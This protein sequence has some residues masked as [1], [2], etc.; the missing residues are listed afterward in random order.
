MDLFQRNTLK[1]W[2]EYGGVSKKRL[3]AYKNSNISKTQ[4]DSTKVTKT[5]Y[6]VFS[7]NKSPISTIS[8]EI[9]NSII[10]RV[11]N[12]KYLEVIIN[13]QL[14]WS[15]HIESVEQQESRAAARKPRDAASV[16]F[17]SLIHI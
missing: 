3:S 17:L 6:S 16:L 10:N 7:P 8:L 12:C 4:Q 2:P 13:D 14:K 1:F 9:N 5:C 15:T 11:E